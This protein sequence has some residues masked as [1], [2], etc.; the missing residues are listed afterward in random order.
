MEKVAWATTLRRRRPL[1]RRH[2]EFRVLRDPDPLPWVWPSLIGLVSVWIVMFIC[3]L[4]CLSKTCIP[5]LPHSKIS[6]QEIFNI[7]NSSFLLMLYP[8]ISTI[9]STLV[10]QYQDLDLLGGSHKTLSI[11]SPPENYGI[12][13][14]IMGRIWNRNPHI[15]L[16]I[17][18]K[19]ES[20]RSQR[21]CM[22]WFLR[23]H[24]NGMIH[25]LIW[26]SIYTH[27]SSDNVDSGYR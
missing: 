13:G 6:S 27:L 25:T 18:R 10:W 16:E 22:G 14:R 19:M 4:Q 24:C 12:R 3:H 15:P 11:S 1:K 8:P 23:T 17:L 7:S 26:I 5:S 2:G 20:C 9:T 21:F